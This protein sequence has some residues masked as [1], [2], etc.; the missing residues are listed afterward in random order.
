MTV[1]DSSGSVSEE[2]RELIRRSVAGDKDAFGVLYKMYA[3]RIYRAVCGLLLN[4][5]DALEVTQETFVRAWRALGRFRCDAPFFPWLYAIARNRCLSKL[6]RGGPH[7]SQLDEGMPG[8]DRAASRVE[9]RQDVA[10]ALASLSPE[11]R[12][13]IILRHFEELSY[14]EIAHAMGIPVGTV[15]SRLHHARKA[16]AARLHEWK[17]A[18]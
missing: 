3:P 18:V 17:D 14:A 11:H 5:E 9:L 16:L 7:S 13:V 1:T 2:E 15:M 12:E 6:G 8:D 10:R 4:E